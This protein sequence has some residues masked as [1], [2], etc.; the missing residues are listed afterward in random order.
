MEMK[1]LLRFMGNTIEVSTE[2]LEFKEGDKEFWNKEYHALLR[3][4]IGH[5]LWNKMNLE[6]HNKYMKDPTHYPKVREW[7]LSSF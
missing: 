4:E 2:A 6:Q 7:E 1:Y 5:Q 3:H